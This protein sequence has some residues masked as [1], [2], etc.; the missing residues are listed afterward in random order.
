[1]TKEVGSKGAVDR[2]LEGVSNWD[3]MK[4]WIKTRMVADNA[5]T[6]A[7]QETLERMEALERLELLIGPPD[8]QVVDRGDHR[9]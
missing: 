7:W 9:G 4:A 6:S 8:T 2:H 3:N 5:R 1:M